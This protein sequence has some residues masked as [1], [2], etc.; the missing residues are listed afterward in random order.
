MQ[1]ILYP[2]T[3]ESPLIDPAKRGRYGA[4]RSWATGLLWCLTIFTYGLSQVSAM[5]TAGTFETVESSAANKDLN[6]LFLGDQGNHRPK[7]RFDQIKPILARRDITLTYTESLDDMRL[8]KLKPY[9]AL[10]VFANIDEIDPAAEQGILQYVRQGGGFV[11][12]HCASFCFRN[13]SEMVQLIGAQ[14]KQHGTGVFHTEVQS[15]HPINDGFGGFESWD[16]TYVHHMH[17]DKNR[18]ILSY[19]VDSQGREPWTWVRTEEKGRV[20][21]TAWGH[22]HRTW[23][24]PGFHN[25]LERGIRW[26]VGQ[27]P[28]QAGPYLAE[29]PFPVPVMTEISKDVKPFSYIDVGAKIPNYTPSER[30]GVQGENLSLMQAPLEPAESAKHF[31][32]PAG[33][34]IKLFASEPDLGGKPISMAWDEQ[35]RLWICETVDY[36]NELQ[37]VGTG[38]DRIRICEDTDGDWKADKFTVFAE[39]LSIPSTLTF[40]KGGVIVQNGPQTL[41]LKDTTGDD[42]ADLREV[43]YTGWSLG[44][45]HGGVS[46]FQYGLDNWIWGMQGYNYSEPTHGD[47]KYQGFR[48][49]FFRFQPDSYNLQFVR[50]TDNN[51]WG[52][53]ISEDG[54]IFGS[55]ANHNPSVFMPIAN[56]YYESVLGWKVSLTLRSIADSHLFKPITEKV[57]Q[58]DHHGG[59]TAG[60]GH[61]L[62]TARQYPKEYWNRTAFVN[63]PTGHLIGTYVLKPDGA[64]FRSTSPANLVAS[65]DEW[66]APIMSEVGPDGNMWMIDWYN[67]IIQHNPTPQGFKTGKGGA[68]ETD[69]RDKIHGRIYRIVYT[70]GGVSKPFSL[71][72]AD[73][74]KLV[75]TLTNPTMQWRKHAQRLLV[76]SQ[77]KTAI[78]MLLELIDDQSV[79]EI[80]LNVGAIHALWTLHGLGVVN[81]TSPEVVTAVSTALNHPSAAVRRN[82]LLVLPVDSTSTANIVGN[83]LLN[84]DDA[85]VRLAAFLA[86]ADMPSDSTTGMAIANAICEP[87]NYLD[88]WLRDAAT[89]AGA[90]HASGF[91]VA[92]CKRKA[93][94]G[95]V[96]PIC[97]V[98]AEHFARSQNGRKDVDVSVIVNRLT[99]AE[100]QV[101][102]SITRGFVAGWQSRNNVIINDQLEADLVKVVQRMDAADRGA[103][104]QVADRWGSQRLET[105]TRQIVADL[106]EALNDDSTSDIDRI[107]AA[108]KLV[109]FKS[110]D[111]STT[112]TLLQAITPQVAPEFA[113]KLV[114]AIAAMQED[115]VGQ[116]VIDAAETWSPSLRTAAF[117]ILLL[118][119]PWT[120]SLLL[121]MEEGRL[122]VSDLSLEQRRT[123]G[124]LSDDKMKLQAMAILERGGAIPNANRQAVL[125]QYL[126]S[127]HASGDATNGKVIFKNVCAKC[128]KH[129]G[130]GANI[131]PELTG[132]AVHPKE[133]LLVH[134]LD[135]NRS[136]ESNFRMYNVQ[137]I[138]GLI[139]AGMLSSESKTA[140][141]LVDSQGEKKTILREDIEQFKSS[142]IS[143]MPE[144]FEKEISL[145]QMSNLLE[146]MTARGK[147]LPLDISKVASVASDQGMFFSKDADVERLIF[148]KWGIQMFNGI[149]FNVID[150]SGGKNFNAIML[151]GGPESSLASKM[152]RVADIVCQAPV[153]TVHFLGGVSG[154]GFPYADQ[155]TVSMIARLHYADGTTEDHE[156]L[157]GV[158]F[159]DYIRRVDVPKS[160]FAF[161][162]R[163]QQ[164]RYFSINPA[165]SEPIKLIQLV[166]GPD[167]TAP[168][169]MAVT[170]EGH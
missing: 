69:L 95:E 24:R 63:G 82:A 125:E 93:L 167:G 92:M 5:P 42:V 137:T 85:Q 60:A 89:S 53:G 107:S 144:G 65:D 19:R 67:Y 166:K 38:R 164:I 142:R 132:M 25:L 61:A 21:Y 50:P 128:H 113:S 81:K 124:N 51:T 146:F 105:Y 120:S 126:A 148:D 26:A 129:S 20:F 10:I 140:I 141:E 75:K 57:R 139:L 160:E 135:P 106:V 130:E 3:K 13:S 152:P 64:G 80:G 161:A 70:A 1:N 117:E 155:K 32:T 165:K 6:I 100:P 111:A 33:F 34:E 27:D 2:L 162:L 170:I 31:V 138:D 37:P 55:T 7:E 108:Q 68:Y 39:E 122:Q 59:Y 157:N 62:Y 14:F 36:P 18:T 47:Q 109:S 73:T 112:A 23:S 35:G 9:D 151:Q 72:D 169:I 88:V 79:D 28:S 154:W 74:A 43:V 84:D 90:K 83:D 115:T 104:L 118:R 116:Q 54:L 40:W 58:M 86:L 41:F 101:L 44:D 22:D 12:L 131:G 149:P 87:A 78:P 49:G 136:V 153:R 163:N 15:G 48:Q 30:W 45:T 16:E 143:L 103:M 77:N 76:E 99:Q 110:M 96:L 158:H 114:A 52:L 29:L 133:E 56:R 91:M 98:V 159:A 97:E 168:V 71:K 123:L 94:P 46:N 4:R 102:S 121:A 8:E 66:S 119:K 127:T 17:N 11:P 134:I 147:Y 145:E 156:L 150:P